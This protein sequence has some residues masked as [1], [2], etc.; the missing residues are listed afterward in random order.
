MKPTGTARPAG[1]GTAAVTGNAAR[2]MAIWPS[3][4]TA[5]DGRGQ[6]GHGGGGAGRACAVSVNAL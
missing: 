4:H 1:Q 3:T 2:I 6:A 5:T